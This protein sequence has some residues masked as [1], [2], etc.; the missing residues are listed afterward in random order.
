MLTFILIVMF[1]FV[2]L[3]HFRINALK[4]EIG[5]LYER[6][7]LMSNNVDYMFHI[8]KEEIKPKCTYGEWVVKKY[9]FPKKGE[10]DE[11]I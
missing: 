2:W 6:T 7:E 1:I 8:M 4:E 11:Q 5:L 10:G 3:Q 9:V